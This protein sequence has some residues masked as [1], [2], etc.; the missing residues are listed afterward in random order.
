M[1]LVILY[2]YIISNFPDISFEQA[3]KAAGL[4]SNMDDYFS[5]K[6]AVL[7]DWSTK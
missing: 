5:V 6:D 7:V 1:Q 2:L 3:W 4:S